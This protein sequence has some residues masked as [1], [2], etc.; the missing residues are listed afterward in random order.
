MLYDMDPRSLAGRSTSSEGFDSYSMRE[1]DRDSER[2]KEQSEIAALEAE[3]LAASDAKRTL[4]RQK[5]K[6]RLDR[7]KAADTKL[8]VETALQVAA[9]I[10]FEPVTENDR[11]RVF[12]A[13]VGVPSAFAINS[14]FEDLD[15]DAL[16][17]Y[18]GSSGPEEGS[19]RLSFGAPSLDESVLD[20]EELLR[21][22]DEAGGNLAALFEQVGFSER[23]RA[24][25]AAWDR[26][27]ARA[28]S[29]PEQNESHLREDDS[30][31]LDELVAAGGGVGSV[32]E[33]AGR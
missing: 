7:E 13:A 26:E 9:S 25:T 8:V 14:V 12:A 15:F 21:T 20:D 10:D 31:W 3:K 2:E 1:R 5:I 17:G 23:L 24:T 32:D 18:G 28:S 22:L 16:P 33:A 27:A 4:A 30:A 19:S 29:A 6:M 11:D